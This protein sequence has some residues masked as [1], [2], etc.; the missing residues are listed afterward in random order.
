MA[1]ITSKG[2]LIIYMEDLFPICFVP[3]YHLQAVNVS[4]FLR[5]VTGL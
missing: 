2:S 1:S 4:M 5:R 3:R